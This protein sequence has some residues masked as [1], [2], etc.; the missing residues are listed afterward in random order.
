MSQPAPGQP[1]G[2]GA[3]AAMA[4]S[5]VSGQMA[6]RL[7]DPR[8]LARAAPSPSAALGG[9]AWRPG[10]LA[11][12]HPGAAVLCAA[13]DQASPHAGWDR[14]GHQH[15]AAAA[16]AV[17]P[18]DSSLFSGM[19]GL[20][21]AAVLLAAGRP[22][23]ERV[24]RQV[25]EAIEAPL[26]RTL[27]RLAASGC[28]VSEFDLVSGLTG[29]GVYLLARH[30]AQLGQP[31]AASREPHRAMTGAMLERLL[32]GLAGLLAAP[33]QP[34]RWHTPADLTSGPLRQ[35]FPRGLHN[36]GL[37]HGAPG[38]LALLSLALL[39]GMRVPG[40]A[41]AIH[42]TASWLAANRTGTAQGPD[43]PDG[44]ALDAGRPPATPSQGQGPGRAAWCYGT[45]GVARSLWLAGRAVAERKWQEL[46]ARA[47]RAVASRPLTAWGLSGPGFCHGEAGLLQVLRRFAADLGDPA[48]AAA[49]SRLTT[50]L[51]SRFDP[52]APFGVRVTDPD[53]VLTDQPGL[54]DGAVGIALALQVLPEARPASLPA[55]TPWD[56]AFLLA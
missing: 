22:R 26:D 53:G 50:R 27:Q 34:R 9:P 24:L 41:D 12:G 37:A 36:C 25:D 5:T 46:A 10:S 16:A 55:A 48:I 35:S 21:F 11:Q 1:G 17:S 49:A 14:V 8:R 28:R 4:V 51:V 19:A 29:T 40:A 6:R 7:A 13:L 45:P 44:V 2:H 23:Y 31:G 30:Q 47:I 42:A 38:P 3:A 54:L 15:L 43:W 33:G 20:G 18:H 56:R 39:A 32:G 52:A